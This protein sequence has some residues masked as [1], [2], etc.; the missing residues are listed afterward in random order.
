M[1]SIKTIIDGNQI[2]LTI[3]GVKSYSEDNLYQRSGG[4]QH[5]KFF[6]GF[7]NR[8]CTNLCVWSDGYKSSISVK[9][10]DELYLVMHSLVKRYNSNMHLH[11]LQRLAEYSLTEREFAHIIGRIRMFNH[12]PNNLKNGIQEMMLTD[13]QIGMVV[14]DY[15][16]DN[17][18]C[19][20]DD[21][22]ISLWKLYNLFTGANKSTYIDN[23]LDR[24]VNAFSFVTQIRWAL[25]GKE[26]SWYL[27]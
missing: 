10:F 6:I 23:F 13:T 9:S 25:D 20:N 12:L 5:F 2:S 3:G 18:F 27:N 17:S 14:K 22:T 7:K 15:Y 4:D 21:G 24:S 26:D 11:H 8:V 16:K 19:R 1:P